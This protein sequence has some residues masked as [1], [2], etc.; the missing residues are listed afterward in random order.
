[1]IKQVT[2][3]QK[4][5]GTV[6]HIFLGTLLIFLSMWL[7]NGVLISCQVLTIGT[8]RDNLALDSSLTLKQQNIKLINLPYDYVLVDKKSQKLSGRYTKTNLAIFKDVLKH[9]ESLQYG[10]NDYFYQES[11]D[12]IIVIRI[13]SVPEFK[14]HFLRTISYNIVTYVVL[15]T[16][17]LLLIIFQL[18]RL[19]R[20]FIKNFQTLDY[21]SHEMGKQ[22]SLQVPESSIIEF[23]SITQHLTN[24][25]SELYSLIQKEKE[26][27][28]DLTY[29][30]SALSHDVK[31]PLTV[32]KGNLELLELTELTPTQI[33]YLLSMNASIKKF[34]DYF[35]ALLDYSKLLHGDLNFKTVN[36][37]IFLKNLEDD[38][39]VL[40]G[41][42]R[43]IFE[44]LYTFSN[45][46][47]YV[48]ELSLYRSLMNIFTNAI[49][50]LPSENPNL[51][52]IVNE[53][54]NGFH[55]T[56]WNNGP[57][58]KEEDL[59]NMSKLFYTSDKN[60]SSKHHGLGLTFVAKTAE[61][62]H[63]KLEFKNPKEGGASVT[64]TIKRN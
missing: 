29:Q 36:L 42:K 25:S 49:E 32:L 46:D 39:A 58:F 41:E 47:I 44:T 8:S 17:V 2:L 9:K 31:T 43:V 62:H 40:I 55:F 56:L 48:D 54:K 34:E 28:Q 4:I 50:H 6:W 30:I 24:T 53:N 64:M 33:D 14:N 13:N 26:D 27:K 45:T 52:L 15:I 60:R 11:K 22:E 21:I 57:A 63:G 16:A 59:R 51:R 1:M 18:T 23:S 12:K 61:Q 35:S 5:F 3:K 38:V 19:I 37:N 10:S 20:I 7:V